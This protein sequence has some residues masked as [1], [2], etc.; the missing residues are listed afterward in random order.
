MV[1]IERL[2]APLIWDSASSHFAKLDLD[3]HMPYGDTLTVLQQDDYT[4]IKSKGITWEVFSLI[5]SKT[6]FAQETIIIIIND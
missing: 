2:G 3:N 4:Y 6:Y 5:S 1:E